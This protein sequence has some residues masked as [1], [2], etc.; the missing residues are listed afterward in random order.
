MSFVPFRGEV[1]FRVWFAL[2]SWFALWS[3]AFVLLLS[4]RWWVAGAFFYFFGMVS[5]F[6]VRRPASQP[7]SPLCP[8][9]LKE[10]DH[11]DVCRACATFL[12][13]VRCCVRA[14]AHVL[15]PS[16]PPS[17]YLEGLLEQYIAEAKERPCGQHLTRLQSLATQVKQ[18]NKQTTLFF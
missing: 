8:L 16:F 1:R 13:D 4:G 18:T 3:V 7:A 5:F 2:L 11:G 6:P 12:T 15:R 10:M 17:R 14:A 9:P